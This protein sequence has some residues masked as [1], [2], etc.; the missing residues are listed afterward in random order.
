MEFQKIKSRNP[1]KAVDCFSDGA[2]LQYPPLFPKCI[3]VWA[4]AGLKVP[5]GVGM[6]NMHFQMH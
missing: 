6:K 1:V 2:L 3:G 4:A 5:T